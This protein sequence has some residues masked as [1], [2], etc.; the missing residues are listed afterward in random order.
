MPRI[1]R[2][3]VPQE[4][5]EE[6]AENF[7]YSLLKDEVIANSEHDTEVLE[8]EFEATGITYHR[9]LEEDDFIVALIRTQLNDWARDTGA[10]IETMDFKIVMYQAYLLGRKMVYE[11]MPEDS[12]LMDLARQYEAPD[13]YPPL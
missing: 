10:I 13:Q 3:E 11:R 1:G 7:A 4:F 6:L 2:I 5:L 9:D 8:H 12:L